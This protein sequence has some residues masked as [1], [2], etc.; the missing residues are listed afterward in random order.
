LSF[1][2]LNTR[3]AASSK[4]KHRPLKTANT[5][6]RFSNLISRRLKKRVRHYGIVVKVVMV[7]MTT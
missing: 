4:G 2:C 7:N 6:Y 5:K 1:K 3:M